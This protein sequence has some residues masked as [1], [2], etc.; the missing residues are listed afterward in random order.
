MSIKT[1][2]VR[3]Y[4]AHDLRL[5]TFDLPEIG[6]GEILC[7]VISNS[8]CMSTYKAAKA[9]TD[10]KRVPDDAAQNPALIGHEFAGVI[11][12][13]GANW[14]DKFQPGQKFGIQPALNYKGSQDAPGYSYRFCGGHATYCIM[15]H[16]VMEMDCLLPYGGDAF[17]KASLAEPMS[18]IIGAHNGNF[19]QVLGSYKHDLGPKNGGNMAILAG[20][21]PM[22]LGHIDYALHGPRR[23]KLL[24]VTDIDDARLARAATI[25]MPERAE[26]MGTKLVYVNTGSIA[27]PVAHLRGLTGEGGGYDDVFV[28]A[29]VA[30]VVEQGD[31][32]LAFGG[33]LNFFAGPTDK[34]FSARLN[35]YDVHYGMHH[36]VGTSG[37]NTDDMRQAL[38]LM[39]AGKLNPAA[40][41]THVGGLDCAIDTILNLPDIPGG[42]KLIYTH[43]RMPLVALDDFAKNGEDD[44]FYAG[45]AE[46]IESHNGLWCAEAEAYLLEHAPD[47]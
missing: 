14:A 40:M 46:I 23:P 26:C 27:D 11:E 21:G 19:H 22:G 16:E 24:V 12:K 17:F 45:L 7:R 28:L 6:D 35:F 8:I 43:K 3:I 5:E 30:P 9:G 29:P 2:A 38:K 4:G 13:V 25:H 37:G 10:H 20:A 44:P 18:T 15:P 31:A 41:I 42:K 34:A 39:S 33:C 36:V 1:T 47:L 32:V